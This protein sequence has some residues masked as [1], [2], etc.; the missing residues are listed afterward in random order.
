MDISNPL[1]GFVEQPALL[2]AIP[3]FRLPDLSRIPSTTE[4]NTTSDTSFSGRVN[5][6]SDELHTPA[7]LQ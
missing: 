6:V 7:G 2:V 3:G 4:I 5:G 1:A